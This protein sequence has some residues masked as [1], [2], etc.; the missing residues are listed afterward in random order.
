MKRIFAM[1]SIFMLLLCSCK[2]IAPAPTP[3]YDTPP[4]EAPFDVT[5]GGIQLEAV[6]QENGVYYMRADT[7]LSFVGGNAQANS[8]IETHSLTVTIDGNSTVY[9]SGGDTPNA[10]YDGEYWYLPYEELLTQKGYHLYKDPAG[11]R[12][13]T[14]YP[15]AESLSAGVEVPILMYHA[16]SDDLWGISGL[17]VSPANMEKQLQYLADNGYTPIW[18]EDLANI[19]T[20][21]KPVILTFD[22]GYDD[23]YTELFPLLKKYN[24][25]ATVFMI[26]GSIGAEHYLTAD[27][28]QDMSG[29]GLVSFQSHT[30][31]HPDLGQCTAEELDA[32]LLNSKATLARLTG[33]EPFV[34]CYPMGK[35]SEL[36]LEKTAEHYEYGIFM[37]GKTFV[38]GETDRVKIYRKYVSRTTSLDSFASMIK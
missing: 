3:I 34:L 23:N 10:F 18:F 32:E 33:K 17:F 29:S 37:S 38:T 13:Y 1:I 25:K 8:G 35:W 30:V 9:T 31:S 4:V 19:E 26:T 15:K 27:Q 28:I 24:M 12:Y 6:Y 11:D 7:L 2:T 16:V 20:I 36:S 21:E 5:V 14:C 22:D